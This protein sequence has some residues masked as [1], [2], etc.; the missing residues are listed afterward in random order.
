MGPERLGF[1]LD[2]HAAALELYA[3]QWCAVPEDVVQEA[4]L[5]LARQAPPPDQ[6]LAWLYRVVRNA[7]ISA[8]RAERRR[9]HHEAV[10][11]SRAPW[12]TPDEAGPL[13]AAKVTETL[14]G[15]P[16][17]QREVIVAHLW[18]GLTFEQI[19]ELT[20]SSATT[21]HRHYVAGL[22]EIRTRLNLPC[23][24]TH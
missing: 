23:P 2:R 21:A 5:K 18:G 17:K 9:Q 8:G 6:P 3:R 16:A 14:A 22:T 11:A 24:P 15:L 19:A 7:A 10:A 4:F 1:L 12:F 20:E 13:D